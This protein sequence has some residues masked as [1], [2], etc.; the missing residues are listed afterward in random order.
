LVSNVL[1]PEENLPSARRLMQIVATRNANTSKSLVS[2][3]HT[4]TGRTLN[5]EAETEIGHC[6]DWHCDFVG[7]VCNISAK[8]HLS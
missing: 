5:Y 7:W 1:A 8:T 2:S 6:F 4:T 3:A